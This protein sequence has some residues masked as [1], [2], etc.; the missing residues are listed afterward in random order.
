[1]TENITAYDFCAFLF[2]IQADNGKMIKNTPNKL[3]K[4]IYSLGASNTKG[5]KSLNAAKSK[6]WKNCVIT[7]NASNNITTI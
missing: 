7:V 1:M 3:Y 2:N 6:N 5:R 4:K